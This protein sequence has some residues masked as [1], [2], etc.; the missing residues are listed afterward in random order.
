MN[1]VLAKEWYIIVHG[2]TGR[3]RTKKWLLI[4]A[5]TVVIYVLFGWQGVQTWIKGSVVAGVCIHFLFRWKTKAW[6]KPWWIMKKVIKTPY[7]K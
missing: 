2:Q 1:K 4:I 7:D 5:I 6:T 3:F